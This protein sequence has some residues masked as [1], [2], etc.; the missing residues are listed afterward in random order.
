M[1]NNAKVNTFV[2]EVQ[3][4]INTAE[5]QYMS[6]QIGSSAP[7]CYSNDATVKTQEGCTELDLSGNKNLKYY[8]KFENGHIIKAQVDDGTHTWDSGN[9]EKVEA[10]SVKASDVDS[11]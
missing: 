2:D 11:T 5:K 8:V 6:D 7:T 4:V 3:S 9:L 10:S 1:Y